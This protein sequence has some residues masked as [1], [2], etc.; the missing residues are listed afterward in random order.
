MPLVKTSKEEILQKTA[1]VILRQGYR[2]SSFAD[3]SKACGIR[4][5]HFFYY[6]RDKEDLMTQVLELA[7]QYFKQKVFSVA[8]RDDL[9]VAERLDL[10][11]R[12]LNVLNKTESGCMFGNAALENSHLDSSFLS[13]VRVFF[14]EFI[15]ALTHIYSQKYDETQAHIMA[16]QTL[17]QLEG[18]VMM[19]KLFKDRSY[20]TAAMAR[21]KI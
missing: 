18:A 9:P 15:A 13:V 12:K 8:Y 7:Y 4:S 19:M 21:I 17:Q 14:T 6:F 16:T 20:L 2:N 11:K 3:L 5:A 1:Q 10:L